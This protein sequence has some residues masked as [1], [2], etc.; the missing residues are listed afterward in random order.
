MP[1]YFNLLYHVFYIR[2]RYY[3]VNGPEYA[4]M[5]APIA[6]FPAIKYESYTNFFTSFVHRSCSSDNPDINFLARYNFILHSYI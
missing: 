1:I 6:Q 2:L 4:T 5:P 3:A